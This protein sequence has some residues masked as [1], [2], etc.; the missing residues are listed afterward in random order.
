M[1]VI[2]TAALCLASL[3]LRTGFAAETPS[4]VD[5]KLAISFKKARVMAEEAFGTDGIGGLSFGIVSGPDLVYQSALGFADRENGIKARPDHVYRIGSITKQF[6]GYAFIKMV[7]DDEVHLTDLVEKYFPELSMVRERFNHAPPIT[8]VQ[9]ATMTSGLSREPEELP[10]YLEGPASE[11]LDVVIRALPQVRYEFEPDTRYQYSNIGYA[12]LGASLQ[13]ASGKDYMEYVREEILYPLGMLDTD[14]V[15]RPHF[16]SRI[17][18]GYA[19]KNEK[20]DVLTPEREHSG[21]GYKVPNGALYS[22][23]PD[24]AKFISFQLGFGSPSVISQDVLRDNFTRVNSASSNLTSGYGIGFSIQRQGDLVFFGHGGGVAG[25]RAGAYFERKSGMG[26]IV[27]RNVGGGK[28]DLTKFALQL[29]QEV[30][31]AKKS[32]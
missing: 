10:T 24:L 16:E 17:A 25:Y 23:V 7:Q 15:P 6:T 32:N 27:L 19:V 14:F 29:L 12:I 20:V 22:T 5:Q 31:D 9:L 1:R 4:N 28:L 2:L 8:L 18:R 26:V 13:R 30:V 11:W 3:H 21:R